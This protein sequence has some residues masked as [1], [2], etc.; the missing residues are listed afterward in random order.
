MGTEPEIAKSK[1]FFWLHLLTFF[2]RKRK[3]V[4]DDA[5]KDERRSWGSW[6]RQGC[7]EIG[8][9]ARGA[10]GGRRGA[11]QGVYDMMRQWCYWKPYDAHVD[12]TG[13]SALR[14]MV[15]SV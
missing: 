4:V 8:G 2:L 1:S 7:S 6:S 11:A 14:T 3:M 13:L 5:A 10:A 12:D 9:G 15:A